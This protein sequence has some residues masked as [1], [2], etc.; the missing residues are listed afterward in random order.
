[1]IEACPK[2]N[3]FLLWLTW[4]FYEEP[5]QILKNWGNFLFF[6]FNYFSITQLIR[7]LFSPWRKYVDSYGRGFDFQKYIEVFIGN[8]MTRIL[9]FVVRVFIIAAGLIAGVFVLIAGLT[10]F[11]LWFAIPFLVTIGFISGVY[12]LFG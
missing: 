9:G 10:V 12:L 4:H 3:I 5:K 8:F 6:T 11:L 1:M 2:H 7:T